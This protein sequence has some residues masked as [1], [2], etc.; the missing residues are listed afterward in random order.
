VTAAV[1]PLSALV[2]DRARRAAERDYQPHHL[3]AARAHVYA[4]HTDCQLTYGA[5]EELAHR[6]ASQPEFRAAVD[7]GRADL[8]AELAVLRQRVAALVDR[9]AAI[10]PHD[11]GRA[12]VFLR[13]E[14]V[15]TLGTTDEV[16]AR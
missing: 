1:R 5:A 13:D 10:D 12:A 14:L 16:A 15:L 11:A 3:A 2:A 6:R 9:A 7:A 8:L 4:C